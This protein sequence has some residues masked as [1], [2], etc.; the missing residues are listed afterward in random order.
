MIYQ[1]L[2]PF[3]TSDRVAQRQVIGFTRVG[4]GDRS[5]LDAHE[6]YIFFFVLSF[7]LGGGGGGGESSPQS[8]FWVTVF[9]IS[10]S[11]K[12]VFAQELCTHEFPNIRSSC[13]RLIT[14][15]HCL[16]FL[17]TEVSS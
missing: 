10:F 16:Q 9:K 6:F 14:D 11:Q 8:S 13:T 4:S 15:E 5:S 12:S 2:S 17:D 3:K 1:L 7:F